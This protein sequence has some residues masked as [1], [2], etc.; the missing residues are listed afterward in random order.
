M[1]RRLLREPLLHFLLLGAV[2][3]AAHGILL[4]DSAAEPGRIVVTQGQIEG[5]ARLFARARQRPPSDAELQDLVRGHIR[6]EVL[7]REGL[8]LG[9]DRDDPII[10]RRVAHKLEIV[11]EG[12]EAVEPG[13]GELQ[14]Y[15]D[16]HRELFALEPIFSFRHIYLDPKRRETT[17]AADAERM[18]GELN[19]PGSGPDAAGLG[20]PTTL[21]LAFDGASASSVKN[22]L[23]NQFVKAL[24]RI[25]PGPWSGP[26][27]SGYGM[28]LVQVSRRSEPRAPA[29]LEVREA[30]KREWLLTRRAEAFEKSYR[31][32]LQRYTV[33]IEPA[34]LADDADDSSSKRRP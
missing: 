20:D 3:F 21:P 27:E 12:A 13:D 7:Y 22:S 29:L 24:A 1:T 32:L 25:S 33:T 30:V 16:A 9:L 2:L 17:L 28:H 4:R 23:G 26:V 6:E 14:A 11:T 15:L 19:S 18:L 10:R 34:R 5:M 31:N 8:A